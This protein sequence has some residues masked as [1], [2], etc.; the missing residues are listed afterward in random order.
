M[1]FLISFD[2]SYHKKKSCQILDSFWSCERIILCPAHERKKR[3]VQITSQQ[4]CYHQLKIAKQPAI[5]D[6]GN[7]PEVTITSSSTRD[8]TAKLELEIF[9]SA[10]AHSAS[11]RAGDD[12]PDKQRDI[13]LTS[14]RYL[15]MI[16]QTK[17]PPICNFGLMKMQINWIICNRDSSNS[18]IFGNLELMKTY[19][20]SLLVV[21]VME[22]CEMGAGRRR[23]LGSC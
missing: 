10:F 13:L 11:L 8:L 23:G 4:A 17:Y 14:P 2:F 20:L 3:S 9:C 22:S 18:W 15:G 19:L 21:V 16:I 6:L 12:A 5:S 1:F 7:N